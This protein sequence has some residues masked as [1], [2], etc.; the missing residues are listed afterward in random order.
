MPATLPSVGEQGG[1]PGYVLISY[2]R[3]DSGEVGRLQRSLQAAGIQV[4]R[5]TSDLWPGEDW[6]QKIRDAINNDTLVFVACFSTRSLARE[7]TFQNEELLLA[8]DQLRMR[9]P[10][11][12]WLIPVRLDECR[13]P[14]ID[15]GG[16]RTLNSIQYAD[17]FSDRYDAAIARLIVTVQR[18]LQRHSV[19]PREVSDSPVRRRFSRR[20]ILTTAIAIIAVA[21]SAATAVLIGD[22]HQQDLTPINTRI[23]NFSDWVATAAFSPNNRLMATGTGDGNHRVTLWNVM[24][25]A[26]PVQVSV[27]S[28]D[29]DSV[30]TLA[31]SPN[32]Q[33]IATASWDHTVC[34][35]NI[36]DPA[37]P[38]LMADITRH[39]NKVEAV[40]FSPNGHVLA[41]GGWDHLVY[42]WN[43]TDP[44]DTA[45]S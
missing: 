20:I 43:V 2:V 37:H 10:D 38:A 44:R 6:R 4:W 27:F 28:H 19:S 5:D 15:I 29:T 31:F 18:I 45:K 39:T 21:I 12:P 24:D 25:P 1:S 35:W 9:R 42:L 32:G 41:T 14:D 17:L 30:R 13:I 7:K 3:E 8:I 23:M 40:A 11:V 26:Q 34:L 36:E 33:F 22:R 16:G